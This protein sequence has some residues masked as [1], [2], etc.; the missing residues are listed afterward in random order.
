MS[1]TQQEKLAAY[2]NDP[3][4][5]VS[6]DAW[7]ASHDAVIVNAEVATNAAIVESK[8]A[9]NY[10]THSSINDPSASEKG[11]LVGTNGVASTSNP[12]VTDSDPRNTNTRT[13]SA[14][15]HVAADV[16]STSP[17]G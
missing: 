10:P 12:F 14:H 5:P 1:I 17:T 16:S 6:K 13:P 3:T 8:L 9:L 7:V 4:K 11:A 2:T 15:T